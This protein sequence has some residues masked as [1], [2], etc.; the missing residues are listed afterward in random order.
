MRGGSYKANAG[1][2]ERVAYLVPSHQLVGA[3][4]EELNLWTEGE[5]DVRE[6]GYRQADVAI[7]TFDNSLEYFFLPNIERYWI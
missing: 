7:A 6:R 4:L 3:K 2:R 1:R 5:Y